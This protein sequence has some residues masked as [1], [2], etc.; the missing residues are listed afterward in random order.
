MHAMQLPDGTEIQVGP[1]RFKVPE[2]LFQPVWATV[3]HSCVCELLHKCCGALT[4][5]SSLLPQSI[6]PTFPGLAPVKAYDGSELK[7]LP[8][9]P[10][11][12]AHGAQVYCCVYMAA[13][14]SKRLK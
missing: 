6:L 11:M 12:A 3:K 8:G 2:V 10:C 14:R 5:S 1:D 4:S 9:A 13:W 7:S